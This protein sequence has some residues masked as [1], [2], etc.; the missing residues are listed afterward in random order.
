MMS[1][2]EPLTGEGVLARAAQSGEPAFMTERRLAGLSHYLAT[3]I[4]GRRDEIWRRVELGGLNV[5]SAAVRAPAEGLTELSTPSAEARTRQVFWG[6]PQEAADAIPNVLQRYWNTEV[7]PAGDAAAGRKF[8]A[9]NQALWDTGCVLHVPQGVDVELPA[10]AQFHTRDGPDGVFPHNLAVLEEGASATLIESYSSPRPDHRGLCCP[11]TEIILGQ[12]ARLRYILLQAAGPDVVYIGAHSVHQYAESR[13]SLVSAH[14]GSRLEKTFLAARLLAPQAQATLSGLYCGAGTQQVHLDTLQHH[15]APECKSDLLFKGAMDG[16]AR[17][18][19]RGMIRLEPQ[20]QKTD[21]YQQN[22]TLLLSGD[23]RMASIPGLEILAN[24]VRC[25]HGAAAGQVDPATLFYLMS[26]GL[27]RAM[28]RQM[29][30]HGFLEEVVL[31]FALE[32]VVEPLRRQIE[33][34]LGSERN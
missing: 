2:P 15:V 30:L 7:F 13:L 8:H 21:A 16:R 9:L 23:A 10:C 14:L 5:E 28:A 1:V 27:T 26:R 3:P 18:V 25:S 17:G 19:Y 20:A 31:R 12:G 4:P 22:R 11:Q 29:V 24:D 32:S 33:A 34:K 6:T